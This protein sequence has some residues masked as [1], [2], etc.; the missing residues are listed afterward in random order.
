M[1]LALLVSAPSRRQRNRT[2]TGIGPDRG[3]LNGC[4]DVPNC[5]TC[6]S[7]TQWTGCCRLKGGSEP[8]DERKT[9]LF[10]V[11]KMNPHLGI[12]ASDSDSSLNK[13][14][15][16]CDTGTASQQSAALD[17]TELRSWYYR[18]SQDLRLLTQSGTV[19]APPR[20]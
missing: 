16:R 14:L 8:P 11:I 13:T 17:E 3:G 4:R 10:S 6:H 5:V 9:N 2:G 7:G 20:V 12:V 18:N 15:Y 1:A 19:H